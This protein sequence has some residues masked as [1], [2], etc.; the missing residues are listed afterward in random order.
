MKLRSR[1]ISE[2]ENVAT[3]LKP[4][5]IKNQIKPANAI[6]PRSNSSDGQAYFDKLYSGVRSFYA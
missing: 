5:K 1:R 2:K 4:Q 6:V 3:P